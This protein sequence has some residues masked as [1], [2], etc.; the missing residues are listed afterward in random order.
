MD[1]YLLEILKNISTIIIPGLGALT[2]TNK[3]TGEILFMPY[4]N[5]D[6]GKLSSYI[7]ENEN[8]SENDAK[9]LIAKYVREIEAKLNSGESY[10][11]YKF[12]SFAKNKS[13]DIEFLYWNKQED[14]TEEV[15]IQQND[16][17]DKSLD[18]EK[19]I[20]KK[21]PE[22][23]IVPKKP[24]T[25]KKAKTELEE[26]KI[27][28]PVIQESI[29]DEPNIIEPIQK[30]SIHIEENKS[31][32]LTS[33]IKKEVEL[34]NEENNKAQEIYTEEDQWSDDLDVPP[35]HAKIERP[36]KPIIEKTIKDKKK[37]RPAF[38]IFLT[39]GVLIIGGT[40][41]F[42]L[43]Y[44]SLE[45]LIPFSAKEATQTTE[46]ENQNTIK[47]E[48]SSP[49]KEEQSEETI[50]EENLEE[51]TEKEPE[52]PNSNSDILQ[53]TTGM[54]DRN[55]PYHIIAGAFLNKTYAD[56]YQ[57]RLISEGYKSVIIGQFDK[58]YLVSVDSYSTMEEAQSTLPTSKN[59]SQNGW[60]FKWPF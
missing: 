26:I 48:I 17:L 31:I 49:V 6:D 56:N 1:K 14:I 28:E 41:T 43:F 27:E 18:L 46:E 45:K 32:D 42:A 47:K 12:G 29:V 23:P 15:I 38:Y 21:L 7:S 36:K 54:V 34:A 22:Q 16:S 52:T 25:T 44:N 8:M 2:I 4:L 19:I 39:L 3:D 11:M 9:N 30:E 33:D 37:R 40:L 35:I 55:R 13:G 60:I 58:L 24:K 10:D 5:Y 51:D 59:I 50:I 53:T 57:N 20:D